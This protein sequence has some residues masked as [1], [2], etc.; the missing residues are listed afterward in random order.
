MFL[1]RNGLSLCLLALT[2][3]FIGCQIYAG[4][5][6]YNDELRE[7]GQPTLLLSAYLHSPHFISAL[8]ENWESEFLQMGMY[9]LLTVKLRQVG[10]AESRP[11]DPAEETTEIKPGI[12]PWPVRAGGIWRRLYDHSLAIA[13][14]ALFLMSF[15]LHLV[16]SWRL[17]LLERA[18]KG[19]PPITIFEHFTSASFW[20][21]SM[22]NWQSEFLAVFSLVVLTIWLRQKDS[23]QSKP[24]EAPHSQTG[25]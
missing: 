16:G 4:L 22:Q 24:V 8:F 2:V 7:Q 17:E 9:V 23:P 14:G 1:R 6:A 5:H 19:L 21:E 3:L 25:G 12:T 13:F 18:Q 11:L 15:V 10:S 20:F